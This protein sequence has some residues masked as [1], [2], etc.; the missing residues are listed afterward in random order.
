M[1]HSIVPHLWFD[2]EAKEAALFYTGLFPNSRIL[3]TVTLEDTPSGNAESVRFELA[4]QPFQA[5][6]AGPEFRFNSSI[7]LMAV[8]NTAEEVDRLYQA[9]I[10]GGSELMELG[11]YPFS[12]RYAWIRDRYGLDWQLIQLD[13]QEEAG[14]RPTLMFAG[15][16]CGRAEEAAEFYAGLFPQ[17]AVGYVG[18]YAPGQLERAEPKTAYM[19]FKLTGRIFCA[20]DHAM[21]EG[22]AFN[23]AFSLI[24]YCED[25]REIDDYWEKLS[26]VPEAEV[27]GWVKD[28]FG[29]SWQIVPRRMEDLLFSGAR[30][31]IARMTQAM[32]RMKKLSIA[33]LERAYWGEGMDGR[34]Q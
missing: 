30:E 1:E 6:S 18:R 3:D 21:V 27:C 31:Q 16:V 7:S 17:S 15:N 12:P 23:E 32:L 28:K 8:A 5:I 24:V 19:D 9:L 22:D 2:K 4:G 20:M 14:I 10:A 29:V 11:E 25:Q 26:A 13:A 33:E 34:Y